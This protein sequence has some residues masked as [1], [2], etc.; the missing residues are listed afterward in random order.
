MDGFPLLVVSAVVPL[1][2]LRTLEMRTEL[3]CNDLRKNETQV[4]DPL[5]NN[6]LFGREKS[7]KEAISESL[8]LGGF[9]DFSKQES[10][11]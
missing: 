9:L 5:D 11:S 2:V 10:R 7:V 1:P 4:G 8:K 6:V 3:K